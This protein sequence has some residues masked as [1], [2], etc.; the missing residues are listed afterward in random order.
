[1]KNQK[2]RLELVAPCLCGTET[3]LKSLVIRSVNGSFWSTTSLR[4]ADFI[5]QMLDPLCIQKATDAL[6]FLASITSA[7]SNHLISAGLRFITAVISP[8]ISVRLT[9]ADTAGGQTTF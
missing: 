1:M 4:K 9:E 3:P 7:A 8:P 2:P 6:F 5:H